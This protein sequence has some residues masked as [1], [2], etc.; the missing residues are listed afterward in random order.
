MRSLQRLMH[1]RVPMSRGAG[2]FDAE[3][4]AIARGVPATCDVTIHTDCSSAIAAITRY[5][6]SVSQR[7]QLRTSG[8]QWLS[9]ICRLRT[10]R[11]RAGAITDLRWVHAHSDATSQPH[12]GNRCADELAKRASA[13]AAVAPAGASLPLEQEDVWLSMYHHDVDTGRGSLIR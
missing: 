3:L 7:A 2:V 10:Y 5:E 1:G 6:A 13:V 9:F 12:I 11:A 8:R 4:E